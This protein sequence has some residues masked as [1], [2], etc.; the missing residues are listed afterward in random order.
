MS[1]SNGNRLTPEEVNRYSRHVTLPEVG[2]SGQEKLKWSP[3]LYGLPL[4]PSCRSPEKGGGIVP[5]RRPVYCEE[6]RAAGPSVDPGNTGSAPVFFTRLNL[7]F[8]H[9][10]ILETGTGQS[11]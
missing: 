11:R 3:V 8:A 1:A 6:Y 2:V 9:P 7:K 10:L 4:S 5:E